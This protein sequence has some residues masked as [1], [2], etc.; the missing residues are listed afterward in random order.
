MRGYGKSQKAY[1]KA[2]K[3]YKKKTGFSTVGE[4]MKSKGYTPP[5]SD[6]K[7][8]QILKDID[9]AQ[10]NLDKKESKTSTTTGTTTGT[11]LPGSSTTNTKDFIDD[12]K[13]AYKAGLF[14]G[15]TKTKAFMSKYG[16]TGDQIR[17]LRVGID[18]GLGTVIS[19]SDQSKIG[20]NVLKDLVGNLRQEG[21]LTTAS[22]SPEFLKKR[23]S[24]IYEPGMKKS[25]VFLPFEDPQNILE[26]GANLAS[27]YN[28]FGNIVSGIFGSSPAQKAT[29]FGN[30]QGLE[31]EELDN[32]AAAVANDR[33]LY[34][35]LMSTPEM[36]DYELNE[37]RAEVNRN[38]RA[39]KGDPDPISGSQG[40]QGGESDEDDEDDDDNTGSG[41]GSTYTPPPQN[42]FTFFDPTLGKYRSGTYDEYLK[43]VTAKDGGII[44]LENGGETEEEQFVK[45][46]KIVNLKNI[47]SFLRDNKEMPVNTEGQKQVQDETDKLLGDMLKERFTDMEG[48]RGLTV[49]SGDAVKMAEEDQPVRDIFGEAKESLDGIFQ[50]LKGRRDLAED[51]VTTASMIVLDNRDGKLKV[52]PRNRETLE[53]LENGTY[54]QTTRD[55][56]ESGVMVSPSPISDRR[57][58]NPDT[59]DQIDD[60]MRDQFMNQMYNQ[61]LEYQMQKEQDG[62]TTIR[63]PRTGQ[64]TGFNVADGG[65]IG[66]KEGGMNDMMQADSLMFKDP[67]DEGEWEYNV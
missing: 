54:S 25:N 36:Q 39:S 46:N 21:I 60:M 67:S 63:D 62:S 52:V 24:E 9:E 18:Q 22:R 64:V 12:L 33:D 56:V 32:F 20:G 41:S 43:Y 29:Y 1:E 13:N 49:Q 5:K 42:Y 16:L 7:D 37:F 17:D 11:T 48:I 26:K 6:N 28:V 65:I 57:P 50:N 45:D 44:Q 4:K 35:Q 58:V 3:D 8:N 15:G 34:N 51:P 53:M 27:Q 47:L 14:T 61:A 38:M 66:L 31:G 10:K 2:K 19:S 59:N 40:S 30:L 55:A 23:A